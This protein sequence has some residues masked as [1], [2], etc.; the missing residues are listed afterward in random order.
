MDLITLK[1][2]LGTDRQCRE[3]LANIRWKDGFI[4]PHCKNNEAWQ[5][6]NIKFKCKKC[7]HKMSVTSGTV[8]QDSHTPLDKWFLAIWLVAKYS[9]KATVAM[10]QKELELGSNRTAIRMLKILRRARYTFKSE[11]LKVPVE[12]TERDAK[13][14]GKL[15]RIIVIAEVSNNKV[16]R[17]GIFRKDHT[18]KKQIINYIVNNIVPDTKNNRGI[19]S[20]LLSA[21]DFV[22]TEHKKEYRYEKYDGIITDKI[23]NKFNNFNSKSTTIEQFDL[24]CRNFCIRHNSDFYELTFEELLGN[25]LKLRVRKK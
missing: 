16:G 14:N 15:I 13:L 12:I 23:S 9:K 5:T 7:G 4:C 3:Y 20:P 2:T 24:A 19:I 11:K 17:I 8:F 10:L 25:L 22:G 6:E 18:D 21:V 1:N